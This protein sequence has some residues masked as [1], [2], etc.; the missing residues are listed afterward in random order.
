MEGP[1]KIGL[2]SPSVQFGAS[3]ACDFVL[4]EVRELDEIERWNLHPRRSSLTGY[5]FWRRG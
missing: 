2:N 3:M 5:A 4:N 1:D